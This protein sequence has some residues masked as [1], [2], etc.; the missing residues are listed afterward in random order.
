MEG[1]QQ[2]MLVVTMRVCF[3]NFLITTLFLKITFL[4]KLLHFITSAGLFLHLLIL[5]KKV[6][7]YHL[8]EKVLVSF[9]HNDDDDNKYDFLF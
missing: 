2:V 6:Y 9:C 3:Y 1:K 5:E 4:Y 8:Q 7:R